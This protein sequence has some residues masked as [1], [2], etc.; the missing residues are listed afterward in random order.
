MKL[1]DQ[2]G[3]RLR[4]L[5]DSFGTEQ[6]YR[7]WVGRYLRFHKERAGRWV[8]PDEL[9]ERD[10]DAAGWGAAGGV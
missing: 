10:G 3:E 9:G 7:G 6:S 5:H 4:V 1:L 2:V 8:R